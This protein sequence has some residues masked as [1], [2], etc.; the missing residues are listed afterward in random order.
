MQRR[1]LGVAECRMQPWSLSSLNSNINFD[2]N[3]ILSQIKIKSSSREP[4]FAECSICHFRTW[5]DSTNLKLVRVLVSI[6][7]IVIIAIFEISVTLFFWKQNWYWNGNDDVLSCNLWEFSQNFL[8]KEM[9]AIWWRECNRAGPRAIGRCPLTRQIQTS[10]DK[11]VISD[12][13][14]QLH[15]VRWIS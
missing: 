2:L 11:D 13:G 4:I 5:S 14:Y 3:T 9:C 8:S 12:G 1:T 15:F 6:L 10:M 7:I